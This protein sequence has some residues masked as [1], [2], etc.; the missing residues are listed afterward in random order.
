M[1]QT[2]KKRLIRALGAIT[3]ATI[4]TVFFYL[5]T[6]PIKLNLA[7]LDWQVIREIERDPAPEVE[8]LG[9]GLGIDRKEFYLISLDGKFGCVS[10]ERGP[11]GRHRLGV[12]SYGDG[13]FANGI[14]ESNG[15]KYLLFSGL[16]PHKAIH[17]ITV[18]VQGYTY[19]L[20]PG[21]FSSVLS[22]SPFL[23]HCEVDSNINAQKV[24]LFDIVFYDEMGNDITSNYELS[25]GL[26]Q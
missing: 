24:N 17:K 11:F 8:F 4:C 13:S 19:D 23:T 18:E 9:K 16:D 12:V 15:K 22:S 6:Y 7:T 5:Q 2:N 10:F 1:T 25:A 21:K 26:I 14:I 3:L 20:Y